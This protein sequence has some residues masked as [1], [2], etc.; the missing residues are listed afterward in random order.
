MAA[1]LSAAFAD[2]PTHP[3]LLPSAIRHPPS[4]QLQSA[5]SEA[6][7]GAALNQK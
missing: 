1:S 5:I 7:N 4:A 6:A 2:G 3:R